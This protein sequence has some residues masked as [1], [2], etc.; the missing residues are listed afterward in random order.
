[1]INAWYDGSRPELLPLPL[2]QDGKHDMSLVFTGALDPSPLPGDGSYQPGGLDQTDS[3][4]SH[5]LILQPVMSLLL[6]LELLSLG[7]LINSRL[8]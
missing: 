5:R 1:M 8:H 3:P 2:F 6:C 4:R 7:R